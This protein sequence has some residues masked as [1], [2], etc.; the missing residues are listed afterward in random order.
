MRAGNADSLRAALPSALRDFLVAPSGRFQVTLTPEENVWE[1]DPMARFVSA[2]REIDPNVTG[3]PI[4]QFESMNDMRS[5]FI[6][7]GS[8]SFV[9]V[10]ILVWIDFRSVRDTLLVLVTLLVGLVWTLGAISLLGVSLNLANFFAIPILMG[11][12][13]D[14]GIHMMQR[15]RESKTFTVNF[16]STQRAVI[17]TAF[18][19]AIGFGM[20][21]FASHRG[22][23]SLGVVMAIGSLCCLLAAIVLLPAMIELQRPKAS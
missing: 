12:G 8:L 7:M 2:I 9:L 17:L 21:F 15:A 10:V 5:S 20:L 4:T 16:G 11:I 14:S 23:Q 22:L 1:Y 19:T 6:L 3:V 18:T 13:V